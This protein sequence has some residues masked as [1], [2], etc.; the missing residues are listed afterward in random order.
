M[1]SSKHHFIYLHV[2][3]TGGNSLQTILLPFSDDK[4]YVEAHHDEINRFGVSGPI[5][6]DKHTTLQ[7]YS[8]ALG[9]NFEHYKIVITQRH[10]FERAMSFYFS[11]HRWFRRH[12]DGHWYCLDAVWDEDAFLACLK[13]LPSMLDYL[14]VDGAVRRPDI[15]IRTEHMVK[16]CQTA[17]KALNLPGAEQLQIPSVNKSYGAKQQLRACLSN[18]RLRDFVE[19]L[20][21]EDM[22]FFN[23]PSYPSQNV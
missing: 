3:K 17:F 7:F 4:K 6:D 22:T 21:A 13:S 14:T 20:Y 19:N 10:P 18:T 16:D 11:P 1:I 15:E 23:Y 2:P 9:K 5:T 8:D 12:P